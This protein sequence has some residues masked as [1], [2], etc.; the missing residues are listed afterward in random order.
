MKLKHLDNDDYELI[1]AAQDIIAK[2][3]N[4]HK[5]VVGAALRTRSVK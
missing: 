5:H 1:K 3:Y 4:Y 2:R